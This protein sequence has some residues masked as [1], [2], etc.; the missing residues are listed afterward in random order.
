LPGIRCL[1]SEKILS[2]MTISDALLEPVR[3]AS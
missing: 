1:F 3:K 2:E